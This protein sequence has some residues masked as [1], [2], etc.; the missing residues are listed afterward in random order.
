MIRSMTTSAHAAGT[1]TVAMVALLAAL[2]GARADD[3][4][5]FSCA[6]VTST[7]NKLICATPALAALD[8]ELAEMFTTVA[9]QPTIDRAALQAEESKWVSD[10]QR[11][12][13][14]A[15]CIES[16]YRGR[17]D[18]LRAKSAHAAS[19]AADAETRPFPAPDPLLA[20]A[21]A[22]I[23]KSCVGFNF[24]DA[25]KPGGP[26]PLAG[27]FEPQP[28]S[29]VGARGGTVFVLQKA[30]VRVAFLFVAPEDANGKSCRI[31]DLAVLPP[32][33]NTAVLECRVPAGDGNDISHGFGLRDVKARKLVA[34]WEIDIKNGKLVRQPLDVL[35]WTKTIRCNY[36]EMGE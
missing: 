2:P 36:P 20:S 29:L 11:R 30:G 7:V 18:D 33:A 31:A 23:G 32:A 16:A 15:A 26:D 1:L 14:D 5:S 21:R 4:P 35:G 25:L 28:P 24:L 17:I 34:Y 3:G 9:A 13:N 19:P 12:C 8:R 27:F 6:R 22:L 10:L